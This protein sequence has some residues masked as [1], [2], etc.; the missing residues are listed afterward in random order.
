MGA[1]SLVLGI[2]SLILGFIIP[3]VTV[4]LVGTI[5]GLIGIIL[6]VLGLNNP[7][8]RGLATGG[9]VCS[10]IGVIACIIVVYACTQI[11]PQPSYEQQYVN[12]SNAQYT[13]QMQDTSRMFVK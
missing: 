5:L 6:G 8:K 12:Q 13:N 10:I 11:N 7:E 3:G 2:L 9:M 4:K 1:G